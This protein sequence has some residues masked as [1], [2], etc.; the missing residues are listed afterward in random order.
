[1]NIQIC[2]NSLVLGQGLKK[3]ITEHLSGV[4]VNLY[5]CERDPFPPDI[6]LFDSR[7]KLDSL[8]KEFGDCRFI[9]I[10]LGLKDS[11]LACLLFCHGIHGI[12]SPGLDVDKFCKALH[13]VYAGE[14]WVEQKHLK[15]LLKGERSLPDRKQFKGLSVQD[16]R[17]ISLVKAGKK[18]RVIAN[19]LCL[20]EATVKAHLS[21]IYRTLK[22]ENR[23][24]LV[25]LAV[26]SDWISE[27][28]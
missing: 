23:S 10:D 4:V 26:E 15:A 21:R 28:K 6:V 27:V 13:A 8:K 12:I 20:S 18:N 3:I 2:I 17:I 11:E 5:F 14:V 7:D 25:A 9:C 19:M 16:K 1:M 24:S 22:V